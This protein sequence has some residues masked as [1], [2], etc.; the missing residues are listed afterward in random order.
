MVRLSKSTST[1][2]HTTER[3]LKP[4][5]N[6]NNYPISIKKA[7]GTKIRAYISNISA[8]GFQIKCSRLSAFVLTARNVGIL[9][10]K[11]LPDV[12]VISVFPYKNGIKKINSICKLRYSAVS[13]DTNRDRAFAIGLQVIQHKGNSF[14][15]VRELLYGEP[16]PNLLPEKTRIIKKHK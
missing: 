14:E 7:D 5:R 16:L 13:K 8:M 6:I 2:D 4:R 3:R 10:H 15:V 9:E 12:E 11:T 1:K